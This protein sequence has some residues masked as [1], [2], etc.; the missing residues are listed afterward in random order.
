MMGQ[1]RVVMCLC[2]EGS[3]R[4]TERM[5]G[6]EARASASSGVCARARGVVMSMRFRVIPDCW[7]KQPQGDRASLGLSA[8]GEGEGLR[9]GQTLRQPP[10]VAPSASS[11]LKEQ[12]EERQVQESLQKSS[13]ILKVRTF[14][15][16]AHVE[17]ADEVLAGRLHF[18][19]VALRHR[20]PRHCGWP[21]GSI[22]HSTMPHSGWEGMPYT[23][24]SCMRMHPREAG[25][26][27]G[28][29]H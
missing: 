12:R 22:F 2:A 28:S 20:R 1:G 11:P 4:R 27:F 16:L 23:L 15:N 26:W 24:C 8:G 25:A 19:H 21:G 7:S 10:A 14:K 17:E 9:C 6:E 3:R 29:L 18:W 5:K 13:K